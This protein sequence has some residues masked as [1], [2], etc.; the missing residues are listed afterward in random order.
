MRSSNHGNSSWSTILMVVIFLALIHEWTDA[1]VV[2]QFKQYYYRKKPKVEKK[3]KSARKI[4]LDTEDCRSLHGLEQTKCWRLCMAPSCY[5]DIYA[6][7][8]LELGEIDVRSNSFKGCWLQSLP[9]T[10]RMALWGSPMRC[11]AIELK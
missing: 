6:H 11:L 9:N 8:E 7:D 1:K 2:Y 10:N 5:E 3:F 4:C